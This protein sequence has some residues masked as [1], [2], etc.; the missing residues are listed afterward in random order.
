[1]NWVLLS[2]L[3]CDV[4]CGIYETDSMTHAADTVEKMVEKIQAIPDPMG[5]EGRNTFVRM[6][7]TKEEFAKKC[8][9]EILILW[10]DY[11]KAE[12][13]QKFP[14]LHEK[15][16]KAAKL[17]SEAKRSVNMEKAQQLKKAVAEIAEIF[18]KSK[19]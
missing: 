2:F 8:K 1:M 3:H 13:L 9:E 5:V 6:I 14:E 7:Q 12:H 19:Q 18:R 15:V 11:F 4:P 17:C 10:T 16:W